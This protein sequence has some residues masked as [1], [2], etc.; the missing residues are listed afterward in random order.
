MED[1]KLIT[2][3]E[4]DDF[5]KQQEHIEEF[6]KLKTIE[7]AKILHDREPVGEISELDIEESWI[8]PGCIH[9]CYETY[10]CGETDCDSYE[11]PFEFLY[12]ETY[13]VYFKHLHEQR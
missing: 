1:I 13:P 7:L 8:E 6:I 12:N 11:L 4:L 9:V 5:L 2:K 10:S 3:K